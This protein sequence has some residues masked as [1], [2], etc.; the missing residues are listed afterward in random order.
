M[1][2]DEKPEI[3]WTAPSDITYP[4]TLGEL[5]SVYHIDSSIEILNECYETLIEWAN[6]NLLPLNKV[7]SG[8]ILRRRVLDIDVVG[9]TM[10]IRIEGMEDAE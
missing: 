7:L 9:N 1:T 6:R 5:L 2:K 8:D 4:G 3:I 10:Q